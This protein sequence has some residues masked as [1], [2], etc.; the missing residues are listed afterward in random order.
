MPRTACTKKG[1]CVC[2]FGLA[3]TKHVPELSASV[4]YIDLVCSQER[5]GGKVLA[6]LEAYGAKQG[7]KV[8]AL[9]A[10]VPALVAIY[11]KKGISAWPTRAFLRRAR[12]ASPRS[13]TS[14]PGRREGE[15][16]RGC[17]PTGLELSVARRTP[18]RG[19]ATRPLAHPRTPCLTVGGSRRGGTAGG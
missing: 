5:M 16:E 15:V 13:S 10:A 4:F 14:S 11:E 3:F 1:G 12:P 2:G 9:R 18:G 7:A 17:T 19:K 6:A 8:A